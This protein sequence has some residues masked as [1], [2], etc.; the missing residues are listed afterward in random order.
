MGELFLNVLMGAASATL[1]IILMYVGGSS[2]YLF[3]NEMSSNKEMCY[4]PST[5]TFKC[6]L[7]NNGELVS[8]L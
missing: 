6:S 4:Q 5:Q 3:F 2:K 1:I 8:E 7:Y